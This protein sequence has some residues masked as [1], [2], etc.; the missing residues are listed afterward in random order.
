MKGVSQ[1]RELTETRGASA[2]QSEG[3]PGSDGDGEPARGQII[4][5]QRTESDRSRVENAGLSHTLLESLRAQAAI[6][7]YR[8]VSSHSGQAGCPLP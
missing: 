7:T 5:A 3:S 2:E 1:E 8:K 6:C 4:H